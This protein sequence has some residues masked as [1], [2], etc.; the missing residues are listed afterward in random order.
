MMKVCIAVFYVIVP[1]RS[2]T[3]KMEAAVSFETSI[4]AYQNT[5][6]LPLIRGRLTLITELSAS[7]VY[8]FGNQSHVNAFLCQLKYDQ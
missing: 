3:L 5:A 8:R 2:Y 7:H 4:T 1:C 6:Y